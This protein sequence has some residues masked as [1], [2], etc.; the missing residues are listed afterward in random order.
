MYG[1]NQSYNSY[2]PYGNV[3]SQSASLPSYMNNA[4]LG[5]YMNFGN[6]MQGAMNQMLAVNLANQQANLVNNQT[7]AQ[8]EAARVPIEQEQIR[9]AGQTNRINQ[10]SPLLSQLFSGINGGGS[11]GGLTGFTAS[12]ASGTPFAQATLGGSDAQRTPTNRYR[13]PRAP[14]S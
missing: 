7:R 2:S 4:L 1:Q 5:G 8:Y 13:N 6:Q 11:G 3:Y 9:Q 12:D 10:L 14:R